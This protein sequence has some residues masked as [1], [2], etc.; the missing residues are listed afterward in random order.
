[1]EQNNVKISSNEDGCME[2]YSNVSGISSSNMDMVI[3][4][5]RMYPNN[6]SK[7]MTLK[8]LCRIFMSPRHAK[9]LARALTQAV[10]EYEQQF[11]EITVDAKIQVTHESNHLKLGNEEDEQH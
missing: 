9:V 8:H 3:N 5:M 10:E 6:L 11:G 7:G 2:Y 1:M 4:F